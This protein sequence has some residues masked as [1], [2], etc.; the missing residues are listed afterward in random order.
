MAAITVYGAVLSPYVARVLI[1]CGYKG[2]AIDLMMPKD[3]IKGPEFLKL[4]PFGKIPA[5][6]DG[7]TVLYEPAV[8]I[9]YLEAKYKKNKLLPA[10]AKAVGQTRL[11]AAI[12]AEYVQGVGLKFFRM[13]RMNRN[14]P[15]DIEAAKGELHKGLDALEN[16][17]SGKKFA[18]GASPTIADCFVVPALFFAVHAS[19]I[20]GVTDALGSRPKLKAY[21]QNARKDKVAGK[22]LHGM[23][24]RMQQIIA[25]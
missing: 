23:T 5:I 4:N 12:A 6:K 3:G 10:A 19:A 11:I 2:L 24:E 9:D 22:I 16:V 8:I 20:F 17:M 15:A 18:A 7:T 13:K 25:T 14:V 1:A 21:W